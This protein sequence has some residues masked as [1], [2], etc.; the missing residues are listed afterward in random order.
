M[1]EAWIRSRLAAMAKTAPWDPYNSSLQN[2]L[3]TGTL[4]GI[5]VSSPGPNSPTV[6]VKFRAYNIGM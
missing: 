6:V 3:D 1:G 4:R 2:A 5:T